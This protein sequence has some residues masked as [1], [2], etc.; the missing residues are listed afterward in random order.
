MGCV[1][2]MPSKMYVGIE[3]DVPIYG[4]V[5]GTQAVALTKNNIDHF[6]T[7]TG[8]SGGNTGWKIIDYASGTIQLQP[9]NVGVNSTT[10]TITLT[11]KVA[12]SGVVVSGR[13]YTESNYDKITLTIKGTTYLSAVSG[14][15]SYTGSSLS[16]AANQSIV[17][18]YA[19][20]GSQHATNESSTY[21]NL[22]CNSINVTTTT[23]GIIGYEKKEVARNISKAYLGISTDVPIKEIQ[24]T[25]TRYP[26]TITNCD[27]YY[28]TYVGSGKSFTLSNGSTA[29]LRCEPG[30]IGISS[31]N[32]ALTLTAKRNL[33][34]VK[35][36]GQYYTEANF[37]KITLT[38]K[39]TSVL[40]A[41]SGDQSYTTFWTGSLTS[42]QQIY[43]YYEKDG[44]VNNSNETN[45][46][47]E[48]SCDD[49]T[50]TTEEEV[51]TGYEQKE[52]ARNI[53]KGYIGDENGKARLF[54]GNTSAFNFSGNSSIVSENATISGQ[55]YTI[56]R[57]SSAGTLK[58]PD[59]TK[60]WMCGGGGSGG[61]GK[62]S[63]A[64]YA[65]AGGG[66]G[67]GY[68]ASGTLSEGSYAV[69]IGV[70]GTSTTSA[71]ND[72]TASTLGSNTAAGGKKGTYSSGGG[73]GGSGG[74]GSGYNTSS[75]YGSKPAGSG[76]GVTTM[77]YSLSSLFQYHSAGGGGGGAT[78]TYD[79]DG[80]STSRPTKGGN[81]GSKGAS[82]S[83]ATIGTFGASTGGDYGGGG[84]NANASYYGG[85]GGGASITSG[86]K[87]GGSGY[88]G[89]IYIFVPNT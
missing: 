47:F 52:V 77:P 69:T 2:H 4:P 46:Y 82:G 8:G 28:F 67:G 12:L 75:S 88:A 70:G 25:V 48:I 5:T 24:Q 63:S 71:S 81:G 73:A 44:S 51:I 3:S 13:Y 27:S 89:T 61:Y 23:Q 79:D 41:V 26:L 85:G 35:V 49:Y 57:L 80:V 21:F 19:K 43:I 37:D 34:N 56:Y 65:Y 42:G 14:T 6:F 17:L 18:K 66:G 54:F 68:V 22:S 83:A 31:S 38:V 58:V 78:V 64:S 11:A 74:G 62:G 50:V 30:N 60:F 1:S 15:S 36:K 55:S 59:N 16:L 86:S 45:T 87:A 76:A 20:D 33:T 7:V 10:A 9:G 53:L 84:N 72:G 40:S 32:A 29:G 39:G